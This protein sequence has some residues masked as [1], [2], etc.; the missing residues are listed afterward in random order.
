MIGQDEY[1]LFKKNYTL[2]I[3]EAENAV[4]AIEEERKQSVNRNREQ[5]S[6][7]EIFKKYQNITEITR[8]VV[9]DL[10][11]HIEIYEEKGIHIVFRYRDD[12]DKLINKISNMPADIKAQ[13]AM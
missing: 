11:E 12:W 4:A 5:V 1:F 8:N 9:V 10:I 3:Q 6:W 13:L 7:I 2:K